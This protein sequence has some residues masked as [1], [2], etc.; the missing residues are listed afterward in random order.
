M[1]GLAPFGPKLGNNDASIGGAGE[2]I[3]VAPDANNSL[4]PRKVNA[5]L[6]PFPLPPF[7]TTKYYLTKP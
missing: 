1:G 3:T 2:G 7:Y 4:P 6:C 5:Q